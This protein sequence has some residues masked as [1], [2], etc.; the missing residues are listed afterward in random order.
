LQDGTRRVIK[1]DIVPTMET[2]G[3]ESDMVPFYVLVE[4]PFLSIRGAKMFCS[5]WNSGGQCTQDMAESCAKKE[6]DAR[7][8][9]QHAALGQAR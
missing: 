5:I 4:G 8:K 2:H 3:W 7:R 1:S 6:R 9:T